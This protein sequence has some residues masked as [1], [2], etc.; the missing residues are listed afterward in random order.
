MDFI[1]EID[2]VMLADYVK[3]AVLAEGHDRSELFKC[4]DEAHLAQHS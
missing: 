4:I 1:D 2:E 3:I